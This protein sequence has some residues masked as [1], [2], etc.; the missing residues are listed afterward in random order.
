MSRQVVRPSV[1]PS[2]TLMYDGQT[3]RN[4]SKIFSRLISLGSSLPA[5]SNIMSLLTLLHEILAGIG[6]GFGKVALGVR[7]TL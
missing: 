4:T 6:V 7:I 1:C 3:G 2:V 5:G